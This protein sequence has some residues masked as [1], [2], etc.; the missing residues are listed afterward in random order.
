MTATSST[1]NTPDENTPTDGDPGTDG[2]DV[3][4][5]PEDV[6]EQFRAALERKKSGNVGGGRSAGRG[7][8]KTSG[9]TANQKTQRE[10][11]RKSGG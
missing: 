5:A 6:R 8:G 1:E 2:T 4:G 10:F 9:A 11:R 3:H 7:G